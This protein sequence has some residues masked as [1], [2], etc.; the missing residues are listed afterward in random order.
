MSR[1]KV[2]AMWRRRREWCGRHTIEPAR[3]RQH[4]W[5]QP[6]ERFGDRRDM[7]EID[8]DSDAHRCAA[9]QF[10]GVPNIKAILIESTQ[11]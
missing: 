1:A 4:R 9:V 3:A 5:L 6:A 8:V 10:G 2:P 11:S 7:L